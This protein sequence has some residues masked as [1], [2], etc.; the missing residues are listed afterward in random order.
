MAGIWGYISAR[1][2]CAGAVSRAVAP[3]GD[4][5]KFDSGSLRLGMISIAG[6]PGAFGI[7][8]Y[9]FLWSPLAAAR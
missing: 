9:M 3:V 1:A 6:E 7:Y 8:G 4:P 2:F 5:M